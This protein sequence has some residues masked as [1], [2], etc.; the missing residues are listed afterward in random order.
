LFT[1][2][3]VLNGQNPSFFKRAQ[4]AVAAALFEV[5]TNFAA[6]VVMSELLCMGQ[7]RTHQ[8]RQ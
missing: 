7:G 6:E 5:P 1:R 2:A 3:E 4:G 8:P